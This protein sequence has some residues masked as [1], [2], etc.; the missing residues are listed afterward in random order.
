MEWKSSSNWV[1]L[2][3]QGA[4]QRTA[5]YQCMQLTK[6]YPCKS[7]CGYESVLS[8]SKSLTR[9]NFFFFFWGNEQKQHDILKKQPGVLTRNRITSAGW[10]LRSF[11]V[12]LKAASAMGSD[13]AAQRFIQSD[14]QNLQGWRWHDLPGR[15]FPML[16]CS[17]GEKGFP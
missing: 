8:E 5:L 6:V 16:D 2:V 13:W 7:G 17:H 4:Y 12:L 1:F 15:S 9:L 3:Y 11:L 10:D 14:F